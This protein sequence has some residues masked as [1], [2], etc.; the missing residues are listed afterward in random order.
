VV[1][2]A[3]VGV[4]VVVVVVVAVLLIGVYVATSFANSSA[5]VFDQSISGYGLA[6]FLSLFMFFGLCGVCV[7]EEIFLWF[8]WVVF[9]V[10]LLGGRFELVNSLSVVVV[11]DVLAVDVSVVVVSVVVVS[12]VDELS[13]TM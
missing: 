1:V 2:V 13:V 9:C 10:G 6:F 5:P 3:V 11:A 4:V 12:L 8:F 7:L